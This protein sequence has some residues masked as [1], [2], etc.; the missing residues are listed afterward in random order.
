M[1]VSYTRINWK[2]R[3]VQRPRTYTETANQ[4]GSR[5]DTPAPGTVQQEGTPLNETNLNKMDK[6][7]KDCADA[8]NAALT[9][10]GQMQTTLTSHGNRITSNEDGVQRANSTNSTQDSMITT[11]TNAHNAL[12]EDE[13]ELE[14]VVANHKNDHDNPHAVSKSQ[15]GLGNVPNVSTNDQTPTYTEATS[16]QNLSSGE[17]L[18]VA[19]GKIAR[20]VSQLI[21]HIGNSNNPH[22]V[23]KAQVGLGNVP[24]VQTNNQTPTY[25]AAGSNQNLSS[26]ETLGTAFGKI[27]RAIS[28]LWAHIANTTDAHK[29]TYTVAGSDQ[30]LASGEIMGTA[31]GKLA[32]AVNQLYSHTGDKNN[33]HETDL[34]LAAAQDFP[35]GWGMPDVIGTYTGNGSNQSVIDVN[36]QNRNGQQIA[37][38]FAPSKVAVIACKGEMQIGGTESDFGV[39]ST[40]PKYSLEDLVSG[41][42]LGAVVTFGPNKNFYHSGCGT[43]YYT[44]APEAV[45]GRNHGGAVVYGSSFIVQYASGYSSNSINDSGVTY[46]YA[47]WR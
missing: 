44:A 10:I 7:I 11:L 15:V 33:P 21:S 23:T 9:T 32:R 36:G 18:S 28:Q 5:T 19:F 45:L 8:I 3:I 37:L 17:K 1:A 46:L 34:F 24:N 30:A 13:E 43:S 20:A 40:L 25:T 2:N 47:A 27:A 38:P 29:I 39:S 16:N 4:D 41:Q 42:Q 26:G 35:N 12:A 6:G 14:N 22:G 31:F